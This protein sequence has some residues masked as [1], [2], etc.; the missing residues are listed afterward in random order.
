MTE[1]ENESNPGITH[2]PDQWICTRQSQWNKTG[3]LTC[4]SSG[5]RNHHVWDLTQARRETPNSKTPTQPPAPADHIIS[6]LTELLQQAFLN[7]NTLE[8]ET[9]IKQHKLAKK[10]APISLPTPAP[11]S[12]TSW[13]LPRNWLHHQPNLHLPP[14]VKQ[15]PHLRKPQT[16]GLNPPRMDT[17]IL[18]V[19]SLMT[20]SPPVPRCLTSPDVKTL[21]GPRSYCRPCPSTR[22]VFH[23]HQQLE[24]A[25]DKWP[26]RSS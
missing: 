18:G 20:R 12:S 4:T 26:S 17:L 5:N 16:I 6:T 24:W 1:T 22:W 10:P 11:T 7:N 23:P 3:F 2:Q 9:L 13:Q 15:L 8:L 21:A 19:E 25:Q 14:T